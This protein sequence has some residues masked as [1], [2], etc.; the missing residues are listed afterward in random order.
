MN[1]NKYDNEWETEK[2]PL[3]TV[4]NQIHVKLIDI[5]N[6]GVKKILNFSLV[7]RASTAKF[8]LVLLPM[9]FQ[10]N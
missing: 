3:S 1:R 5:Y 9:R 6:S 7:P 8:L 10:Q 2:N 4:Y